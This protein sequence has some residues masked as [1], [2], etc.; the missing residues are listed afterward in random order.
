MG[1]GRTLHFSSFTEAKVSDR[2]PPHHGSLTETAETLE[3]F[4]FPGYSECRKIP[5]TNRLQLER[6][7]I[8]LTPLSITHPM[9]P[10]KPPRKTFEQRIQDKS[11]EPKDGM[12]YKFDQHYREAVAVKEKNPS[13]SYLKR[14]ASRPDALLEYIKAPELFTPNSVDRKLQLSKLRQKGIL[15]F[16]NSPEHAGIALFLPTAPPPNMCM[17]KT[18]VAAVT[19]C[20]TPS[21]SEGAQASS[22]YIS[23]PFATI[24]TH[25][26][27]SQSIPHAQP[28]SNAQICPPRPSVKFTGTSKEFRMAREVSD[29]DDERDASD[30]ETE[31]EDED[32]GKDLSVEGDDAANRD[33]EDG[34]L[35]VDFRGVTISKKRHISNDNGVD[36]DQSGERC[37][38][39]RSSPKD[40][41]AAQSEYHEAEGRSFP[42]SQPPD[43]IVAATENKSTS[44]AASLGSGD[45]L[46]TTKQLVAYQ[47]PKR[48]KI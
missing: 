18:P 39:A 16:Q 43:A 26:V 19:S 48:I 34:G 21:D 29:A 37:R 46:I 36:D 10:S 31:T 42:G 5:I 24:G 17:P 22:E 7:L 8:D 2:S 47:P 14:R 27:A 44:G 32:P 23:S 25:L 35:C 28:I 41:T 15:G 3:K 40:G 20:F 12:T 11:V 30:L 1:K 13:A 38:T 45:D 33:R 4:N 6:R 9:E